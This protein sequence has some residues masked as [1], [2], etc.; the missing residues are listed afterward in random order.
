MAKPRKKTVI[1]LLI[2]VLVLSAVVVLPKPV[3]CGL[4]Q[5]N[6][7]SDSIDVV[8]KSASPSEDSEYWTEERMRNTK[9][10]PMPN[11]WC[12]LTRPA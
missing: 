5:P 8:T 4:L 10:A 3:G 6:G 11:G 9:Y 1:I 12:S 2:S 7:P